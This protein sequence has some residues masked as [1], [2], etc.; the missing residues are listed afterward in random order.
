MRADRL[1]SILLMLQVHT[2]LTARE[3]AARLEV[4]E[5]TI[6]RDMEALSTAGIPVFAERGSSGGWSLLDS[7]ETNL[8]GLN[9]TE[10]QALFLTK[11]PRLLS[12]LGLDKA[13][14]AAFI[15]LLAALPSTQRRDADYM[16][17]RILIDVT[18]W[19][20]SEDAVPF[21]PLVQDAIWQERRV[22]LT[23]RRSD[24]S[25]VERLLDPLGLVAK[26]SLW[27]LVAAA[28]GEVRTY[29]VS[30][31]QDA[32]LCDE[33][34]QRPQGFDLAAFWA[35]SSAAFVANLPRYP[36]MVRADPAILS[37][38]RYAGRYSRIEQVDP[39]GEDGRVRVSM[40]FE[41]EED[42]REY[43]L[44][45]GPYVEVLE[46]PELREQVIDLA[47]R[48]VAFYDSQP[49]LTTTRDERDAK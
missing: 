45:L 38:M 18:G 26:G 31:I 4:S 1:L 46:P 19:R 33:A 22:K 36:V 48:V 14:E 39:P 44:G 8:T 12:D 7:Y 21:L 34:A 30:R 28:E 23:Y 37:R 49:V 5:R 3:L 35:Q 9:E 27:Y 40:V 11:P 43:L 20:R 15:K 42:A 47:R 13:S 24:G 17:Q 16:R 29:R 25:A 41:L 6:H 10:I 32:A 2:R